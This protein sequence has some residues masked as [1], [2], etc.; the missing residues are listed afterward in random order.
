MPGCIQF[1]SF[2]R[3]TIFYRQQRVRIHFLQWM[4]QPL[5]FC[6]NDDISLGHHGKLVSEQDLYR[7]AK[8]LISQKV[9]NL[10]FVTP[11]H[12]WPHV[13]AL[14]AHLRSDGEDLPI[15]Y[16]CSGYSLPQMIR[17]AANGLTFL[18]RISS[19]QMD[20]LRGNVW[21]TPAILNWRWHP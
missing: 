16:N 1:S 10:N 7:M 21:V 11:D 15:L 5:F 13:E 6:Q 3:G 20:S 9:Q 17:S 4:R 12:F 18:C 2:W 19:L 14:C 8:Y